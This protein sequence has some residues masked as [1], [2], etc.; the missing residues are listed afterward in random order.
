MNRSRRA[1]L[2]SA[3]AAATLLSGCLGG[4]GGTSGDTDGAGSTASTAAGTEAAETAGT[5]Q[6]AADSATA[7]GSDSDSGFSS[8]S[9]STAAS[10]SAPAI[11]H[12]AAAGLGSQPVLGPTLGD[13]PLVVAFEDPSCL[14][15]ERFN[16]N[17]FPELESKL[18]DA[19]KASYAYRN[20]PYAYEWGRPAM[21]ALEATYARDE[22]AFWSLEK[23]Y[24][25]T[26]SQFDDGNV[27]SRTEQF[28]A[29]ETSVNAAAVIADAEAG[30]YDRAV[31]R[32]V[33]A[34]E[35]TGVVST[36]TFSC[37]ATGSS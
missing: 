8:D 36:P 9:A 27:L 11:D 28:L 7:T 32:D 12:P 24:F 10:T 29:S 15:C 18:I 16:S 19:E 34:G 6:P 3:V 4:D 23:H 1:F 31:E 21:G 26:Q 20:F 5:S 14:N 33:D 30:A 17:T 37:F 35:T 25:T 22:A 13:A 2:A